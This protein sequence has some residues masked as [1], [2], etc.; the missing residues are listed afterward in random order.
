MSSKKIIKLD[1]KRA[2]AYEK[3]RNINGQHPLKVPLNRMYVAYQARTLDNCEVVYFNYNLAKEMGIIPE[4][5]PH[6][7]NT[8]LKKALV[9]SFGIRIINEY[10]IFHDIPYDAKTVKKHTYMST[11]YLQ[12]QHH[13]RQ[14][15]TS[16]DGRSIWNGHTTHKG[17]TWDI[18]SRGTGATILSPAF[19]KTKIAIQSGDPSLSYGCGFAET[20]E[21]LGSVIMSEIYHRKGIP[22]ERM[23]A[24]INTGNDYCVGVRAGKNLIRPAHFFR[25]LKQ[26]DLY[27]IKAL[28]DY[29]IE[30]QFQ[31]GDWKFDLNGKRKYDYMLQEI[32]KSFAKMTA[33]LEEEYIF[34]W[35]DWDG[36]NILTDGSILDYGSI[37]QFGM[38]HDSY[39]YDD[40]QRF[41]TNLKEQKQKAKMIVQVF[42]QMVDALKTGTKKNLNTFSN[43][44][45]LR[46][47]DTIYEDNKQ[48]LFLF[49]AGFTNKQ[50][51]LLKCKCQKSVQTF[52]KLVYYFEGKKNSKG[53]QRTIDGINHYPI[54]NI[55]DLFRELPKHFQNHKIHL[56]A[57]DMLNIMSSSFASKQDLTITDSM[58]KKA[59]LLQEAY[60]ELV[61]HCH[62]SFAKN[63]S[64][65]NE[66]SQVINRADR[67]T[68]DAVIHIVDS[69][70][71]KLSKKVL[72][73][74]EAQH[75]IDIFIKD[76]ILIPNEH[77]KK[78]EN[79]LR[80]T[81]KKRIIKKIKKI[82]NDYREGI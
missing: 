65:I 62:G 23:L 56:A 42:V 64:V 47:F 4:N 26:N 40:T 45:L 38:R 21:M 5:H 13:N 63:M 59:C 6:E 60:L 29:Y 80:S 44:S 69:I 28:S 12:L 41:S 50:T 43:H 39:R 9:E 25:F 68:G 31:N 17:V 30:R 7:L 82:V 61:Q 75:I 51:R 54:F 67:I 71:G 76:Q 49:K 22:T 72:S 27:N 74:S 77:I 70:M 19:A 3:I 55:R 57:Q 2:N 53:M 58:E 81:K 8:E 46:Q 10:D 66:R 73:Y 15:R 37:R 34:T 1:H 35:L 18:S 24:I 79:A 36:D 32:T 33:I 20:D 14:G 11:R 52:Q 16:G 78:P 48:D